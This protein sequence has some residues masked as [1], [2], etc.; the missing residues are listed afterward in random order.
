MP[1]SSTSAVERVARVLAGLKH[2]R[3]ADGTE[4]HASD[5]VEVEWHHCIDNALAVLRTLREPDTDMAVIGDV[6]I[7]ERMI[8][9]AIGEPAEAPGR[10][11]AAA[12]PEDQ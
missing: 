11:F 12:R 8:A 10:T 4:A 1:V 7:W 3:N 9:A 2:S 5:S 6:G